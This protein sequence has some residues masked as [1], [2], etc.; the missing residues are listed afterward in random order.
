VLATFRDS[1]NPL[2]LVV[3]VVSCPRSVVVSIPPSAYL[4]PPR[5][6]G[7]Q[8][9]D[10]GFGK[11]VYARNFL[12][13]LI[14]K[15]MRKSLTDPRVA[16]VIDL[17]RLQKISTIGEHPTMLRCHR[18]PHAVAAAAELFVR[19]WLLAGGNVELS[20]RMNF[21]ARRINPEIG[22]GR[23]VSPKTDALLSKPWLRRFRWKGSC[24]FPR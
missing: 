7:H 2:R 23:K 5:P 21:P 3:V 14:P 13:S 12:N 22:R 17:K 16:E 15:M 8:R 18:A 1:L 4:I 19:P 20:C 11:L 9:V 6:P 10:T 24:P